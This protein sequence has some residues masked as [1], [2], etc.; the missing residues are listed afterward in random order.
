VDWNH[1]HSLET[2]LVTKIYLRP[3]GLVF[4][5]DAREM[6]ASGLAFSL[7]GSPH[8]G[9]QSA[10]AI[11]REGALITRHIISGTELIGHPLTAAVTV[12][13]PDFAGL[14]LTQTR[15]MGIVNVTP[16]SFSD[17]GLFEGSE[18]AIAHGQML[19]E[20]GADILDIGGESTRPGSDEVLLEEERCRIMPVIA[21][22]APRHVVS[23]DTRKSRL[24]AEAASAGAKIVNDVS[25]LQFDAASAGV[26]AASRLPVILMHAQG[27]PRTMQLAPKY[28]DV[29]LDVYDRLSELIANAEAAGIARARICIDPGIGFGKNIR[30]N[31]DVMRQLALYHGLGVAMLVGLSRKGFVGA[32]TGEKTAARRMAG[33]I[34]GALQASLMG[35]HL[36]RVHDV[37]E[38]VQSL[39]MLNAGLNPDGADV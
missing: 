30:H 33:S 6:I 27:S 15:I 38:T 3:L 22:L 20:Q 32:V 5:Q 37:V 11:T 29:A 24:M 21:G 17:G 19:A 9:F 34:G 23:V 10:E 35:A 28:D 8:I 14:P 31:L 7:G 16:D 39:A 12:Q 13:R 4:G 1:R 25:A 26:V 18:A 36:L 2:G